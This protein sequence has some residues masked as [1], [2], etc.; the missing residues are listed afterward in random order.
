MTLALL[1]WR[2]R[3][4]PLTSQSR[5]QF[6]RITKIEQVLIG[7]ILLVSFVCG[8]HPTR[9]DVS[10]AL[11]CWC[12]LEYRVIV[13]DCVNMPLILLVTNQH[14]STG[15]NIRQMIQSCIKLFSSFWP[16]NDAVQSMQTPLIARETDWKIETCG[17]SF[18]LSWGK[19]VLNFHILLRCSCLSERQHDIQ[20]HTLLR[21]PFFLSVY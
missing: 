8:F 1:P 16:G 10:V 17:N 2:R 15:L 6:D 13:S 14:L 19:V 11:E 9:Y 7:Q 21:V 20:M 18:S 5:S 3:V 12:L 4:I